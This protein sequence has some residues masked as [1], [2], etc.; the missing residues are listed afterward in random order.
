MSNIIVDTDKIRVILHEGHDGT[1]TWA[2][3]YVIS[4]GIAPTVTEALQEADV[5]RIEFFKPHLE[6]RPKDYDMGPFNHVSLMDAARHYAA[7]TGHH[8]ITEEQRK[9]LY[10]LVYGIHAEHPDAV[11]NL[12][13]KTYLDLCLALHKATGEQQDNFDTGL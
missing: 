7:E 13:N 12:S 8:L 10:E 4:S 3:H 11:G 9:T 6:A 1:G 2:L 5:A